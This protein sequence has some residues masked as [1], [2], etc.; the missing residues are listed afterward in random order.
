MEDPDY[1]HPKE[2]CEIVGGERKPISLPT[3]YRNFGDLIEHPTPGVAR[4]RRGKL[5]ARLNGK[6]A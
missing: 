4:V 6:G 1:I 3:F 2:C 5:I